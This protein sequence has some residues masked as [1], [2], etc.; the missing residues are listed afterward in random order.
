MSV[1]NFIPQYW[2]TL[3]KEEVAKRMQVIPL[4]TCLP[5]EEV[6]NWGDVI[7]FVPP[8]V[9]LYVKPFNPY[10]DGDHDGRLR[11]TI[12]H[13]CYFHQ[14]LKDVDHY[15][16]PDMR[17]EARAALYQAASRLAMDMERYVVAEILDRTN[18]Y[19]VLWHMKMQTPEDAALLLDINLDKEQLSR[20]GVCIVPSAW[21]RAIMERKVL[22]SFI[23]QGGVVIPSDDTDNEIILVDRNA[24][25]FAWNIPRIVACDPEHGFVDGIKGLALCGCRIVNPDGIIRVGVEGAEA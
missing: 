7:D 16:K 10:V 19:E 20:F 4:L 9:E 22:Q 5:G 25:A 24:V 18:C 12:E 23:D 21:H 14:F 2:S 17:G 1:K 6:Q 3:L 15:Q 13:G 11:L 8:G